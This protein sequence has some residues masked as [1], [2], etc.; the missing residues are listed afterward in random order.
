MSHEFRRTGDLKDITSYPAWL[1]Q[2]VAQTSADKA[3]VVDHEFFA[4]LRDARLPLAALQKFMIGAWPTIEQFPRFMAMNLK[5]VSYGHSKGE[6]MARH[7]L[8][9]NIR[10]EQKH[11][12]H[13]VTWAKAAGVTLEQLHKGESVEG[14]TAL[15][16]WCW[17]VCDRESLAVAIAATNYAVEG[18]TGEWSCVVCSKTT[19][20]ESLP[21]EIRVPAMRWLRV[22]AEYDD[23]HPWEALDIVATLL[24]HAPSEKQIAQVQQAIR[25]SYFYIAMGM[26]H[27]MAAAMHGTFDETASNASTLD[28]MSRFAAA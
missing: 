15:A 2:V 3:R 7:Y 22:H 26:D 23:T 27:A 24:G 8:I 21:Q 12:E 19:Y 4:L 28:V 1:Q 9:Q 5:K 25:S 20:A 17:Y 14:L 11:A 10:V 13:W 18:A 6:D 16:Q